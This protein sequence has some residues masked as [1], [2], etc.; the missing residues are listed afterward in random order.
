MRALSERGS[1]AAEINLVLFLF[2]SLIWGGTWIAMKAGIA[3]I[4][5]IFFAAARYVLVALILS[6][7]VRDV[8]ASFKLQLAGRIV[9][10]GLVVNTGTYALLFWGMQFVDSGVA[11]VIN[12][13]LIPVGL[14]ALS[15]LLGDEKATWRHALALVLGATGL[16]ALFSNKLSAS[17]TNELWGVL[18]I[19]AATFCY[20]LGTVLSR[21]LLSRMSP[22]QLTTWHAIVG[23]AGLLA[24]AIVLEPLSRET[25]AS[26]LSLSPMAALLYLAVF[27]TI[28]AYTIYLRLVR[29]W[30]ATKAGLYPFISPIIALVLGWIVFSEELGLAQALGATLMLSAAGF[31]MIEPKAK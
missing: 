6:V 8:V 16:V 5:P 22:L 31:A 4:P 25:V 14:F 15:A 7:A 12:M 2:M 10:T 11:G 29:D 26:L 17:A 23:S 1:R 18:A 13:S 27:G 9:A 24:I 20:C 28:A 30:G 19:I 3:T 21:P